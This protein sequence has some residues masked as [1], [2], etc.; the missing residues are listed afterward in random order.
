MKAQASAR[1]GLPRP[2][3]LRGVPFAVLQAVSA[4]PDR[5]RSRNR[6]L[7][8]LGFIL[9]VLLLIYVVLF[10]LVQFANES[11]TRQYTPFGYVIT[12][13]VLLAAAA[14]I[15]M[16]LRRGRHENG[17]SVFR[18]A[19]ILTATFAIPLAIALLGLELS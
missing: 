4:K 13:L 8:W 19:L 3:T 9:A 10:E 16:A 11:Q 15:V 6:T 7:R 2:L 14:V 5:D 18:T 17:R 12:G 1:C